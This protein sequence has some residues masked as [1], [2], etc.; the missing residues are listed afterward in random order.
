M[1]FKDNNSNRSG[2][3][4]RSSWVRMGLVILTLLLVGCATVVTPQ[5]PQIV[6]Q[7]LPFIRDGKTSREEV[8]NRLGEPANR[9]EGG[10]ILTYELCEDNYLKGRLRLMEPRSNDEKSDVPRTK[11]RCGYS[12]GGYDLFNQD[13]VLSRYDLILVFGPHDLVERHSLVFK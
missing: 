4:E 10:R 13:I 11:I 2:E 3:H 1:G 5:D 6:G 12:H 7:M 9:Y 8:L